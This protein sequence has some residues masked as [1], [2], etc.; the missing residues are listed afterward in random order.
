MKSTISL[1]ELITSAI[2]KEFGELAEE[3]FSSEESPMI[4][5]KTA[6]FRHFGVQGTMLTLPPSLEGTPITSFVVRSYDIA[7]GTDAFEQCIDALLARAYGVAVIGVPASTKQR[8]WHIDWYDNVSF[9]E[10]GRVLFRA[11]CN[12]LETYHNN[13]QLEL[14][15]TISCR[16]QGWGLGAALS[17]AMAAA[18]RKTNDCSVLSVVVGGIPNARRRRYGQLVA[19][20]RPAAK[21]GFRLV[22]FNIGLARLYTEAK[23]DVHGRWRRAVRRSTPRAARSL[24]RWSRFDGFERQL[25]RLQSDPHEQTPPDAYEAG[26]ENIVVVTVE[27]SELGCASAIELLFTDWNHAPQ[28]LDIKDANNMLGCLPVWALYALSLINEQLPVAELQ[29]EA[30]A[31]ESPPKV[32]TA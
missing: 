26:F 15:T 5:A 20:L 7:A 31:S 8:R 24:Y 6:A 4:A 29:I 10:T 19:A 23:P 21:E 25:R 3:L 16:F 11:V 1:Q 27:H 32:A 12:L 2:G 13:Q 30:I 22:D 14:P 9:V 18:A 17:L 28:V